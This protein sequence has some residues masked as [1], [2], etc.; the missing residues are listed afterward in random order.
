MTLR[1]LALCALVHGL[2]CAADPLPLRDCTPGAVTPCACVGGA[3]GAQSCSTAGTLEACVCPDAGALADVVDDATL[4]DGADV[5]TDAA[6]AL[7]SPD[8]PRDVAAPYDDGCSSGRADCDHNPVNGCEV[9]LSSLA[10]CGACGRSCGFV[11]A[12]A[13]CVAGRCEFVACLADRGDCDGNAA[14]GCETDITRPRSC[15][16]CATYCAD[17]PNAVGSCSDDR[18]LFTCAAGWR[19]CDGNATNGCEARVER[20]P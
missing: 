18:C 12:T 3:S 1:L 4:G 19:D 8:A 6:D 13:R 16:T 5:A 11:G 10:N 9:D 20:C 17:R 14:N 15:G 2:G 7:E